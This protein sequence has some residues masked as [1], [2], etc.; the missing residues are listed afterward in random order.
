MIRE[1]VSTKG[2]VTGRP[3]EHETE[4]GVLQ[5]QNIGQLSGQTNNHF[6]K[7]R[8]IFDKKFQ[9]QYRNFLGSLFA[10]GIYGGPLE[11]EAACVLTCVHVH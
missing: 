6:L 4:L 8:E 1:R 10:A 2:V 9:K 11:V 5:Q 7:E 3:L